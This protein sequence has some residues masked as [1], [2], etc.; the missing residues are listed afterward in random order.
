MVTIQVGAYDYW[1]GWK[2]EKE[3]F[4]WTS[5]PLYR[6]MVPPNNTPVYTEMAL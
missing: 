4:C 6:L 1:N 5:L 2:D 3:I